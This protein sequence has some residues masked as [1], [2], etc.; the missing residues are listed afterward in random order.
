MGGK[1]FDLPRMPRAE[2][3]ER[4]AE[5]RAYLDRVMPGGYRIPRY[6]DDKVDFGDMDVIVAGGPDWGERREEIA[7]DLGIT[8]VKIVG[9]VY[10][11]VYRGLQTD[12]F[13]VPARRLDSMWAFMSF[14]DVGNII[15]R[16]CRRF[17]LTWGEDGLSYVHRRASSESYRADLPVTQDFARVCAFLG[18][19]HA[20][21][22]RGFADLEALF[23]WVTASPHFSVAP[24]LDEVEGDM[25]QKS[26]LRPTIIRFMAWLRVRGVTQRPAFGDKASYLPQVIAA[27]P[28]AD[29]PGKL[30]LEHAREARAVALRGKWS[31]KLVMQLR[32][33][34]AGAALGEFIQAFRASLGGADAFE[35]WVLD[36]SDDEIAARIR[37]FELR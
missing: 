15:G 37:A 19:D 26:R 24:Y 8:Q 10:S 34:L 20:A 29:L 36:A 11:T 22:V 7:R 14:N 27:F 31:G 30:A 6:Y 23:T 12:F 25:R 28:E 21:W 1:L 35:T 18:L 9:H 32:P 3:L 17:N 4:E 33:E 2:Y 5:I 13:A 16:M